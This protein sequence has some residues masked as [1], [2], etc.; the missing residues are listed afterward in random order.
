MN[1]FSTIAQA[2]QSVFNEEADEFAKKTGFI[3]RQRNIT[4]SNF[5]KTLIFAWLQPV[6]PAIEGLARAGFTHELHI[7]AQGLDKRFTEKACEFVKSVLEHALSKVIK[8]E[9]VVDIEVLNRFSAIYVNDCS[10]ITL[11]DELKDIWEG[12][13]GSHGASKA[14][15]KVDASIELKTG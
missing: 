3:E 12:S 6:S 14:A 10:V 5:I 4:G 11:P 13:G 9:D 7:S 1:I 2:M 8:A 15:L